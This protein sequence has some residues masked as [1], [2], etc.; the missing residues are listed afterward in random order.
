MFYHNI[1]LWEDGEHHCNL[2]LATVKGVKEPKAVITD[3][4]PA[5]KTLWQYAQR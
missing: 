1:G 2:V 5:L 4:S 3:E